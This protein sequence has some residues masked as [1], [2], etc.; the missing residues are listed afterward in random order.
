MSK[1]IKHLD[2]FKKHGP[3]TFERT[4][5]LV[6]LCAKSKDFDFN[7]VL[8]S[9][10]H[11]YPPEELSKIFRFL[12][13]TKEPNYAIW[14]KGCGYGYEFSNF[15][16]KFSQEQLEIIAK[17]PLVVGI[18]Y[19]SMDTEDRLAILMIENRHFQKKRAAEKRDES[20]SRK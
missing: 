20:P 1:L 7:D 2:E 4:F 11:K 15:S 16:G 13:N 5:E 12:D 17:S 18:D 10:L 9:R 3:F 19:S 14:E 8:E 6:K